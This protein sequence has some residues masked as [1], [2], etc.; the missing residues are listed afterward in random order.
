[1]KTSS[2]KLTICMIII[3]K[4]KRG[5]IITIKKSFK[6]FSTLMVDMINTF[7]MNYNYS[8]AKV[9]NT[10]SIVYNVQGNLEV[11]CTKCC[12]PHQLF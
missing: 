9:N 12:F 10:L 4:L 3:A 1:M 6:C 8:E 11:A 7:I 5:F 2:S